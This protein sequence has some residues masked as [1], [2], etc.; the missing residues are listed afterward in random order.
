MALPVQKKEVVIYVGR[1]GHAPF[2]EWLDGLTDLKGRAKIRVRINRIRLGN[3]GD[4]ESVGDG[5]SELRIHQGPGYRVYFGNYG[6]RIVV[7]L[8]GGDKD[9]QKADIKRARRMF[10]DYK[11]R[12]NE[13]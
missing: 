7:L 11:E 13:K 12:K 4:C 10:K 6:R 1:D 5:V 8:T 9:S 2:S 3:P